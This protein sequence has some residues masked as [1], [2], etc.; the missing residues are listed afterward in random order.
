MLKKRIITTLTLQN[1]VLFRTRNFEPDYRYTHNFIDMW[2]VDEIIILDITRKLR[3]D[4]E[5]KNLFFKTLEQISKN[6]VVPLTVGCGIKKLDDIRTLLNN[7]ADK[8]VINSAALEAPKKINSFASKY[9]KQCIVVSIDVKK[10]D[11]EFIVFT[12]YGTKK[13]NYKL[14]DWIK[15]VQDEGAGEIF[16]QSIEFDGS[17]EGYNYEMVNHISQ[18][19]NLPLIVSSGAGNWEHFEKLFEFDFVSAASTTNIYHFTESSIKSLKNF[20]KAKN[21]EIRA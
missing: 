5:D 7:G 16:L 3:F 13:T 19:I 14:K 11:N 12:D 15:I 20:L 1:G 10:I 4:D 6:I 18:I 8:V 2:S 17:L 9:G 21:L